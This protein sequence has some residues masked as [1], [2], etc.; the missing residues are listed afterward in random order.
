MVSSATV[1]ECDGNHCHSPAVERLRREVPEED[2]LYD[3]TELFRILGDR[4][5]V[6]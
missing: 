1:H 3:L 6:V 5:S 2:T 4:K